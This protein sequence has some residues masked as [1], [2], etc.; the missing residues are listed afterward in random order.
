MWVLLSHPD[1][2]RAVV[3]GAIGA[4]SNVRSPGRQTA[5]VDALRAPDRSEIADPI[6][7]QFRDFA[8]AQKNDLEALA[9]CMS[10]TWADDTDSSYARVRTPV[11][12]VAGTKD[13]LAIN[14]GGLHRMIPGS[15]LVTIEGR[16]HL[17]AVGDG[18]FKQ[19]VLEFFADAPA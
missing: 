3:L 13:T 8:E 7:R 1:R 18:R 2:L 6:A 14:P 17:N 10:V 4:V 5:I 12:I 11:M 16:D 9:A 19:A 15:K